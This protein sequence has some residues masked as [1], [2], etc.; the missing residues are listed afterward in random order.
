MARESTLASRLIADKELTAW[1][2][3]QDG[4]R[5]QVVFLNRPRLKKL[6]LNS[7]VMQ[8]NGKERVSVVDN[9]KLANA[10]CAAAVRGWEGITPRTVSNLIPYDLKGLTPEEL[11]KPVEFSQANMVIVFQ[12]ARDLD[13]FLMDAATD[14]RTFK[15]ELEAELGN[16]ESSLITS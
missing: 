8:F 3:H 2:E 15:P 16:S 10:F 13:T 11:D 4:T 1:V 7:Q 14:I 9:D 6:M 12:N 5:F